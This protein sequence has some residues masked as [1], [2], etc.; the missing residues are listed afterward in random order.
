MNGATWPRWVLLE[1]TLARLCLTI[2]YTVLV[3]MTAYITWILLRSSIQLLTG[4]T[5]YMQCRWEGLQL[6]LPHF[7]YLFTNRLHTEVDVFHK[8]VHC[9]YTYQL[10]QYH[11]TCTLQ[12]YRIFC[13][14]NILNSMPHA[15]VSD[16]FSSSA[17]HKC[18]YSSAKKFLIQVMAPLMLHCIKILFILVWPKVVKDGILM[19]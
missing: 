11:R 5:V 14:H 4:G 12:M 19:R 7:W 10:L 17:L 3:D 16:V 9:H 13:P 18:K 6:V 15:H 1:V 8:E 2:A